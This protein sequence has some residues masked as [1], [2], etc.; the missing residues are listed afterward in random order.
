MRDA[1]VRN[2]LAVD[3]GHISPMRDQVIRNPLKPSAKSRDTVQSHVTLRASADAA[4]GLL[5][6]LLVGEGKM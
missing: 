4:C 3:Y 5:G 1:T 6:V 2:P